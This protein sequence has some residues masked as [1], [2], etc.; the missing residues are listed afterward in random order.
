MCALRDISCVVADIAG[1]SP[2]AFSVIAGTVATFPL[3]FI[4][5]FKKL[6][7]LS[8]LGCISTVVVT[9]TVVAAVAMDPTREKMPQQVQTS[10]LVNTPLCVAGSGTHQASID[11]FSR[12]VRLLRFTSH[13]TALPDNM[14][15]HSKEG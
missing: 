10:Q 3:M 12:D 5:S 2:F 8:L 7:W 15:S 14:I 4:P 11:V 9:V 1:L 13:R 6:S